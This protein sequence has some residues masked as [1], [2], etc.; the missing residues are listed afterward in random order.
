M[1]RKFAHRSSA[2]PTIALLQT[3]TCH[4]ARAEARLEAFQKR[5]EGRQA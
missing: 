5:A 3:G 1:S 2:K 4:L